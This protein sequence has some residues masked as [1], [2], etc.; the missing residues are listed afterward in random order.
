MHP[1]AAQFYVQNN[2]ISDQPG[3]APLIDPKL[4]NAWGLVSSATSPWWIADNGTGRTTLYNVGTGII[5]AIFTVPGV[6]GQP[7]APSGLVFNGGT[8]FVVNNGLGSS[9]ARFIFDGE[10]GIITGFRGVPIVIAVP[11]TTGAYTGS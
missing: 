11:N 6:M 5:P 2:L 8:G 1:A 4:V 3:Q 10:D 9:P 7:G